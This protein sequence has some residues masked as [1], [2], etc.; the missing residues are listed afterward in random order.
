M[1]FEDTDVYKAI[2]GASFS[3]AQR[4]EA[5]L[6]ARVDA[7]IEEIAA[8]QEPDGYLYTNRTV[9]PAHVLP[10]A[11]PSRWSNLVMSH[12]LYN[13]GHLYEAAC[14]HFSATG[15][16]S[17]LEVALRS[18]E[19]ILREFGP[20][21]RHDMCGHQ[22]VE[23]GLA[24]LYRVTGDRRFLELARF[25]LEQR[26]HHEGRAQYVYEEN[27]GYCQ[28][29]QPVVDQREAVGHAVRAVYMYCGMAD[30]AA[31][32]PDPAYAE[33]IKA[34][35]RDMMESKI[36]LTG[37][38]GARHRGEAFGE[39]FELPNLTAYGETCASIGSVMWNHRLFLL[40]G[41]SRYI[42][43]LEQTLYNRLLAGVSLGGDEYFYTSPLESDGTF[44]FNHGSAARQRW[45]DVSCCPTNISRFFPSLPGYVYASAEDRIYANLFVA[46]RARIDTEAGTVEIVQETDYP[47]SGNVRF[48]LAPAGTE[49][50]RFLV[51]IPGWARGILLGGDL[52]RFERPTHRSPTLLI[53]GNRVDLV[54]QD[55]YAVIDREWKPGDC[56]TLEL[57]MPVRKVLCDPRVTGN[58]GLAALQRGPV[59]YCV[60]ERDAAVPLESLSL[61]EETD[62]EARRRPDLLGGIV[63]IRGRSFS[64]VPYYAW[65]NRGPGG[66]RVWLRNAGGG[67][68]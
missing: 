60:E 25:F 62:L 28:D 64:A 63:E 16:R 40:T 57:P 44:L 54:I 30:V 24:R 19:L 36:Y 39:S 8:A 52:Y 67:G 45:F 53:N 23:M 29:H 33:A 55:G 49:R 21:G 15:K 51:R 22:I 27:P 32:F 1:P 56:V 11:G 68:D 4:P 5:A 9:D 42:D 66:M 50:M 17:F 6:D 31:L 18:A 12:E 58:R 47:W 59:V 43:V 2:E 46:G 65:A 34:I 3:L 13:C 35:W 7:L 38:I 26:G 14:A 37:A 41:D 10:F 61:G 20:E 48:T